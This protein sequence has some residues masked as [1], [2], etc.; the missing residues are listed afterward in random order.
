MAV[1]PHFCLSGVKYVAAH[2]KA[3]IIFVD[4]LAQLD[5]VQS[6]RD[7]LPAL[8]LVVMWPDNLTADAVPSGLEGVM[9]YKDFIA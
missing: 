8:K 3:K 2:S 7:E 5:K 9:S 1:A 4:S 6:V